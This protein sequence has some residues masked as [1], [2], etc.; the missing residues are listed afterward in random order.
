MNKHKQKGMRGEYEIRDILQP[1]I[2]MVYRGFGIVEEN[3]PQIRR[4]VDQVRDGG[5]D[6]E[7]IDWIA[8]EVKR[9]ERDNLYHM[10]EWWD[11]CKRSAN[12]PTK[13]EIEANQ[14]KSMNQVLS[15][16]EPP[17]PDDGVSFKREPVLV[18]RK[19]WC[20]WNVRMFGYLLITDNPKAAR[21]RTPVDISFEA[22]LEWFRIRLMSE[23]VL[24]FGRGDS[25]L[26]ISGS[27]SQILRKNGE[28]FPNDPEQIL[29]WTAQKEF[30]Y[31]I[32]D[33]AVR[34]VDRPRQ[35]QVIKKD[36]IVTGEKKF[37]PPWET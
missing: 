20:P 24:Q 13:K 14:G 29:L 10:N 32:K 18:W 25:K 17:L 30:Q 21:V 3:I 34:R 31:G 26:F 22:F 11:Q 16:P 19:N 5:C 23:L 2:E 6:L 33:P 12:Q 15:S 28:N 36:P 27:V 37:K 7:G 9:V 4:N 8:I 35:V 1:H